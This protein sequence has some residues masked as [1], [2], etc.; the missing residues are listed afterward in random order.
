[1]EFKT[2]ESTGVLTHVLCERNYKR[3]FTIPRNKYRPSI[4]PDL[5]VDLVRYSSTRLE[6][7]RLCKL[8]STMILGVNL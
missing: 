6:E 4:F 2:S 8:R 3:S 1:M 7:Y 5:M